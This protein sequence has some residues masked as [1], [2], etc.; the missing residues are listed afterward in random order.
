MR[1]AVA[2]ITIALAPAIAGCDSR[3]A[4]APADSSLGGPPTGGTCTVQFRRDALGSG[5]SPV[6]PTTDSINGAEVS[7]Q[8]TLVR[9]DSEWVV[10]DREHRELWVPRQSV[11]LLDFPK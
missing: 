8:G 10:V 4:A 7:I 5:G 1:R 11:L 6:S 9:V 3:S 2:A